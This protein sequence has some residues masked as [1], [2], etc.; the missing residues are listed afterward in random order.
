[1]VGGLAMVVLTACTSSSV[2]TTAAGG[3]S[4]SP[5]SFGDWS[6]GDPSSPVPSDTLQV[7]NPIPPSPVLGSLVVTPVRGAIGDPVEIVGNCPAKGTAT[8]YSGPFVQGNA[9]LVDGRITYDTDANGEVVVNTFVG[10]KGV[11]AGP[12]VVALLCTPAASTGKAIELLGI[13]GTYFYVLG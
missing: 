1:M 10:G 13:Q 9:K 11:T 5:T 2:N 8:L 7:P 4:P 3:A 12:A 6:P